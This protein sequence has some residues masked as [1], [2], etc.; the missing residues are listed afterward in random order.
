MKITDYAIL[1][2]AVVG[3]F[4][5]MGVMKDRVSF[6]NCVF[7][8]EL[9]RTMDN[10]AISAL[11][12]GY[13]GDLHPDRSTCIPIL[14][15]KKIADVFVSEMAFALYGTDNAKS[16]QR[17][18]MHISVMVVVKADRYILCTEQQTEEW[19][20]FSS[21]LHEKKVREIEEIIEKHLNNRNNR[22]SFP[23][24][25]SEHYSQTLSDYSLLVVYETEK[26]SIGGD[27]IHSCILSG[28][29][30]K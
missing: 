4:L 2:L 11:M 8:E 24:G 21:V 19:V 29:S 12:Q 16:R 26:Y 28:A 5:G 1:F 27:R 10:V 25:Y 14:D 13:T 9:N 7:E 18:W 23:A 17:V 22:I 3:V 30:I 6:Q 15:E 20:T